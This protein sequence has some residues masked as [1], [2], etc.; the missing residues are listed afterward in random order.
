[1][2]RTGHIYFH[3]PCFDGVVSAVLAWDYMEGRRSWAGCTLHPVDYRI[4]DNWLSTRLPDDTAVVDFLFHPDAA[5][6]ADHHP[7]SFLTPALRELALAGNPEQVIFDSGALSCAGL[8]WNRL[9]TTPAA[10]ER[11]DRSALVRWADKID[12]A[13]YDSVEEALFSDAPALRISWALSV[14]NDE[15]LPP[16]LVRHLRRE[17]L[18]VV[19]EDPAVATAFRAAQSSLE[20]GV[21]RLRRSAR[22]S[23][24]GIVLFDVDAHGAV[25]SRY[26]PFYLFPMARYSAGITRSGAEGKIVVMRNPWMQFESA[27]LGSICERY[28]GGGHQRVGA[29]AL[30]GDRIPQAGSILNGIVSA[31]ETTERKVDSW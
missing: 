10:S 4:R 15:D 17:P 7:S 14:S 29:V 19:A 13:R 5:F 20:A 30:R 18:Q 27:P 25:V 26:A 2:P 31:I 9:G 22:I 6:F 28:G 23:D 21:E 16:T 3:S 24:R 11:P 12:S 1:M 8:I